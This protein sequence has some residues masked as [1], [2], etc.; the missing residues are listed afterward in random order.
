MKQDDVNNN[1]IAEEIDAALRAANDAGRVALYAGGGPASGLLYRSVVYAALYGAARDFIRSNGKTASTPWMAVDFVEQVVG[2][3]QTHDPKAVAEL[4]DFAAR[5]ALEV[6]TDN[7]RARVTA[8]QAAVD[9]IAA[10]DPDAEFAAYAA[11]QTERR[12]EQQVTPH[13][14]A[15]EIAGGIRFPDAAPAAG[16]L[17]DAALR[18]LRGFRFKIAGHRAKQLARGDAD[19]AATLAST[20]L[21]VADTT[22]ALDS[23]LR[24]VAEV[25]ETTVGYI[26]I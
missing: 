15:A 17:G 24:D 6:E 22:A 26:E 16:W 3:Y 7:R 14:T 8:V 25:A 21:L 11:K 10:N 9:E 1:K 5:N 13:L 23:A 18:I 2:Q 4:A 12:L 19:G 20:E